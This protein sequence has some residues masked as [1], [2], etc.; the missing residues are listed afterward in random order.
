MASS[1]LAPD[2]DS[3]VWTVILANIGMVE[4]GA[5]KLRWRLEAE[6]IRLDT[7]GEHVLAGP[8]DRLTFADR[9]DLVRHRVSTRADSHTIRTNGRNHHRHR[10]EY[11]ARRFRQPI[12]A[13]GIRRR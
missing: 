9:A 10:H 8:V 2:V 1:A 3:T 11:P 7:D 6:G 12:G 5:L 13:V 4:L